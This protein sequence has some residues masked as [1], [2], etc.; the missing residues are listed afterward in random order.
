MDVL[1][2]LRLISVVIIFLTLIK[3]I[4]AKYNAQRYG[5]VSDPCSSD[6]HIATY[7]DMYSDVK[8]IVAFSRDGSRAFSGGSD[9][10]ARLWDVKNSKQL[11]CMDFHSHQVL[12]IDISPDGHHGLVNGGDGIYLLDLDNSQ[13]IYK[14]QIDTYKIAF[15]PNGQRA[16]YSDGLK[17]GLLDLD[18]KKEIYKIQN[19]GFALN[20]VA[21]STDGR[22]AVG[23]SDHD[24]Y[25]HLI[26]VQTGKE[27]RK[28]AGHKSNATC[29]AF[30]SDNRRI[31]S[32]SFDGTVRLWD[33]VNGNEINRFELNQG[34]NILSVALSPDGRYALFGGGIIRYKTGEVR[35]PPSPRLRGAP[36]YIWDIKENNEPSQIKIQIG[37]ITK[38]VFVSDGSLVFCGGTNISILDIK[39]RSQ[40]K[41]FPL[42]DA[43]MINRW[44]S[45]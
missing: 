37:L 1:S 34:F 27:I 41:S 19:P 30:S 15:L 23:G 31:F 26:D 36:I 9:N 40:Q 44:F 4:P 10:T 11:Q 2:G 45:H 22:L 12:D 32:G 28:F 20:S 38:I 29:V 17:F 13:Q 21:F 24:Y 33:V 39:N 35:P 3:P 6:K 7:A 5:Q 8:I 14:F 18:S 25:I 16:L 42:F 43:F